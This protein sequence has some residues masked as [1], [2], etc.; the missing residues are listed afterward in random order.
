MEKLK[1][2]DTV[3]YH[4][5]SGTVIQAE[6]GVEGELTE[7]YWPKFGQALWIKTTLLMVKPSLNATA[8]T[9]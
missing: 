1:T 2:G 9:V 4:Q 3:T 7:V 5:Y 8:T 6:G